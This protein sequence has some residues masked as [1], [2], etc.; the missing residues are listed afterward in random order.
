ME[1]RKVLPALMLF[2][3][4]LLSAIV[5]FY[6]PTED[7]RVNNPFWN[8]LS[9]LNAQANVVPLNSLGDLQSADKRTTLLLVPYVQFSDVEL[10][11]VRCYVSSG[12][13]LVLL[14]DYGFGNQVLCSLDV[15]MRFTGQPL[16]DPLFHY[17]NK[18][19]PKISDFASTILS[20]NVSSVVLNHA[21]ALNGLSDASVVAFSSSFSFLDENG[22]GGWDDGEPYGPF[23]VAAYTKMGQGYVVAISDPS[24]LIN[25][26]QSLEDNSQFINDVVRIQGGNPQV[27]VDQSH[28]PKTP[29]D[30]AKADLA[31]VY[32]SVASPIGTLI[33]IALVLTISLK[34]LWKNEKN[35]QK[36]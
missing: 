20:A 14:D 6:P 33:L 18:W 27:F 25:G 13:T 24:L 19:L 12:G 28:L 8:G 34:A 21:T 22:N 16:L 1:S 10:A 23:A 4:L 9:S 5:W 36:H 30:N 11:Q 29:L 26:M 7:F 15:N 2:I 17:R 31:V 32:S 3:I 35:D